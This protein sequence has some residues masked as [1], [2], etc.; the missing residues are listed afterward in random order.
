VCRL[1]LPVAVD[2]G[3]LAQMWEPA[4]DA[5][6]ILAFMGEAEIEK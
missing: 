2:S 4:Q 1:I 5:I 3:V 6:A